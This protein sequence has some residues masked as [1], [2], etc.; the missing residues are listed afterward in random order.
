MMVRAGAACECPPD[1]SVDD[2]AARDDNGKYRGRGDL[3]LLFL[4]AGHRYGCEIPFRG[5]TPMY[6]TMAG[7]PELNSVPVQL[8]L[9]ITMGCGLSKHEY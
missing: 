7:I 2:K 1:G 5:A 4:E 9:E 6:R 8:S 3:L